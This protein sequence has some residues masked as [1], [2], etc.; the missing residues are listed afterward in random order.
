MRIDELQNG[1]R[2]TNLLIQYQVWFPTYLRAL[3]LGQVVCLLEKLQVIYRS[4][5][6]RCVWTLQIIL[7]TK[8]KK[9]LDWLLRL[10]KNYIIIV[11][12]AISQFFFTDLVG[13]LYCFTIG[14]GAPEHTWWLNKSS[15]CCERRKPE[16]TLGKLSSRSIYREFNAS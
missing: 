8:L 11:R 1:K 7:Q 15:R 2:D 4:R 3:D 6:Q 5:C 14:S 12:L 13:K 10:D 9:R 16:I